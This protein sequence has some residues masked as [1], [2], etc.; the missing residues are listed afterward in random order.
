MEKFKYRPE[1]DGLRAIA[2]CAVILYQAQITILGYQPFKGG[3]VGVDIFFVIS[4]YLITLN[5][6]E[7]LEKK[8]FCIFGFY[9]KRAR[10]IFPSF[11]FVVFI[12][13]VFGFF[14]LNINT[15][16]IFGSSA[17]SSILF[18][19]NIYQWKSGFFKDGNTQIDP[20]YHIW[21]LSIIIQ[22]YIF[23]PI[24]FLF[25]RKYLNNKMFIII[26]LI[27]IVSILLCEWGWRNKEEANFYLLPSRIWEFFFGSIAAFLIYKKNVNKNNILATLGIIGIFYSIFNYDLN[28][29]FPSLY[30]L[31]PTIG[32]VLFLLYSN[33][34]IIIAKLLSSK[35]IS[36]LGIVSYASFLWHGL[37]FSYFYNFYSTFYIKTWQSFTLILL[38]IFLGFL[39]WRYIEKPF[40]NKK[41]ISFK[42]FFILTI[43][44]FSSLLLTSSLFM[45]L[46]D[47]TGYIAA[48]NLKEKKITLWYNMDERIFSTRIIQNQDKNIPPSTIFIGSSSLLAFD[49]S[50]AGQT[51]LNVSVSSALLEDL[52]GLSGAALYS[53]EANNFF[54]GAEPKL[55]MNEYPNNNRWKSIEEL[56]VYTKNLV[57]N[58]ISPNKSIFNKIINKITKNKDNIFFNFY[59]KLNL[60]RI[61][62][63]NNKENEFFSKRLYD[64]SLIYH[65]NY[66]N[67]SEEEINSS[68]ERF[69]NSIIRE[70]T[71]DKFK[72]NELKKLLLFLKKNNK[73][74]SLILSPFHPD[75]YS[76]DETLSSNLD[77]IENTYR[78]ISDELNIDI[79][80]SY[81]ANLIGCISS[82]FYDAQH[83]SDKCA[84]RVFQFKKNYNQ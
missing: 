59:K 58:Q 71:I 13:L 63:S 9:E 53:L 54:L 73:S 55:I 83:Y 17:Q 72:L 64:G 61:M 7:G 43:I 25:T 79:L 40:K 48:K 66:A 50:I 67:S 29:P 77:K 3:F 76:I 69:V 36:G 74:V 81:R 45:H 62:I 8:N 75:V 80:G 38:T 47:R 51:S 32:T 4:G 12:S 23:F 31:L 18:I 82:D 21:S 56:Y 42:N 84:S 14:I 26:I 39:T 11:F 37:L 70:G 41:K 52:Y 27:S 15:I 35:I 33:E 19:S 24:F 16:S 49:S 57:N 20:L 46:K 68:I 10:K 65:A 5:L 60:N 2:V 44:I 28:I 22:F 6:L 34:K 30:S 78:K 1:I